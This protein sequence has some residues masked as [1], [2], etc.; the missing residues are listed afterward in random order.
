MLKSSCIQTQ[1]AISYY[2]PY[3]MMLAGLR[4]TQH[5][6]SISSAAQSRPLPMLVV[7]FWLRSNAA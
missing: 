7:H 1:V 2:Q 6:E 3:C 4:T 5:T